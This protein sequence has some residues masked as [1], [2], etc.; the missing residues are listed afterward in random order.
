M[1]CDLESMQQARNLCVRAREA[2]LK[3]KEF[4]QKDVDRVVA[5]MADAGFRAAQQLAQLAVEETGFGVVADKVAKNQLATRDVYNLIK[6]MKTVGVINELPGKRI[7]EIAEPMGVIAG[8]VPV[9]NP[10]STVLF[11]S[12]IAVKARNAIVFSPHPNAVRCAS[13]AAKVMSEAAESAGAPPGLIGCMTLSTLQG[14]NELMHHRDVAIILATGGAG[15]V[16]AAYSAGKPAYGV[17]PGNVPAFIERTADVRKAVADI[18]ASKTFDNGTVCASEQAIIAD[19]PVRDQVIAELRAHR[20]YFL[21]PEECQKVAATLVTP[22]LTVRPDCVGRPA[23]II[24]QKAGVVVPQD[25]SILVAPLEGVGRD[26]PLSIE[27]LSPVIAFYVAD[28][29]EAG[30]ERCIEILN[31]G[32]LGHTLVIHSRDQE[33]IMQF[34]LKKPAFRILVNTP[35]THGAVG[36]TTDLDPSMMLG[37]GTYGGNITTDNVTPMHLLNI[38]RVAYETKPLR[39]SD[40]SVDWRPE[41]LVQGRVN[42]TAP[43]QAAL[44]PAA[45]ISRKEMPAAE[46][47]HRISPPTVGGRY[48]SSGLTDDEVERIVAEFL[49]DK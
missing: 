28:G 29:W 4:S 48:G 6:S 38:K 36:I 27:K 22:E 42:V 37:C 47:D 30:C 33:V 11:K 17:G 10:T 49:R 8:I 18:V 46:P 40:R 31:F 1:D 32:G 41:G 20:A 23:H 9:T 34:A 2:Q 44:S 26:Y 19:L 24:A 35:G 43:Y 25:T 13:A 16:K 3:F 21:S 5:A 39:R 12:L 45:G 7:L 14:T 15:L